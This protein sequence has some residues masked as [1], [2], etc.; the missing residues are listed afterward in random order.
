LDLYFVSGGQLLK[1][2]P[3]TADVESNVKTRLAALK[4]KYPKLP[5]PETESHDAGKMS[6]AELAGLNI[7]LGQ[8]LLHDRKRIERYNAKLREF[9]QQSEQMM[10]HNA[11]VG[12]RLI[13]LQIEVKNS[14]SAPANDVLANMHFPNGLKVFKREGLKNVLKPS[15][16]PPDN[17]ND[18]RILP[19]AFDSL[20]PIPPSTLLP[21]NPNDPSLSIRE[22]ASY[23][24]RW[25][26]PKLRQGY[27]SQVD[28]IAVVFDNHPFSFEITYTIVA[29]NSPTTVEGVLKVVPE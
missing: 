23:E 3:L 12:T 2:S 13:E 18:P 28:P 15:P 8:G 6:L 24:V 20:L 26:V 17:P 27:G 5:V 14:G 7:N 9:Y 4:E 16:S 25:R 10:R 22:T 19:R 21:R 29:D 11:A 1:I